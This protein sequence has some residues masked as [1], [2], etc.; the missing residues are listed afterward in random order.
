MTDIKDTLRAANETRQAE[1]DPDARITLAY[2]G[3]EMAGEVGEACNVIKKLERERLGIA[4]SRA[5]VDHLAEELADVVICADL[6]AMQAGIDL[7]GEAVPAKF[8]A[9]SEKT[10]LRTRLAAPCPE[11]GND[12]PFPGDWYWWASD[13]GGVWFRVGPLRSRDSVIQHGLVEGLGETRTDTGELRAR[14]TICEAREN[15]VD[16]ARFFDVERWLEDT[17]WRMDDDYCGSDQDGNQHPLE[18]IGTAEQADLG[19]SVQATIR[20]WQRR[21]GLKLRPPFLAEMR[22]T[23]DVDLPAY[24]DRDAAT[25]QDDAQPNEHRH[26]EP[27]GA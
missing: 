8:N 13:D 23:E 18:Q 4:G 6:I 16:L 19:H 22:N 1:W 21:H 2:R 20:A 7:M 25:R 11:T 27:A 14:F 3:N 10:G 26:A 24:A 9:T 12:H 5:T 15:N 17:A